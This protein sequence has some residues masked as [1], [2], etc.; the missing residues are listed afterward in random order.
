MVYFGETPTTETPPQTK[1]IGDT[2][3]PALTDSVFRQPHLKLP[4]SLTSKHRKIMHDACAEVGL[5]HFSSGANRKARTMAISAYADGFDEKHLDPSQLDTA[6]T[7]SANA[8]SAAP[9]CQYRP[10]YCRKERQG[11]KTESRQRKSIDALI[12]HPGDCLRESLDALDFTLW[13][14]ADLSNK[15]PPQL[16]DD[17]Q[18]WTLVDSPEKMQQ[19]IDEL[20]AAR[21]TAIAFDLELYNRSKY[22]QLTCLLQLT[23]DTGNRDYVIDTLAPG[24]WDTVHGL[25]PLFADPNIVKVGHA[26]GGLDVRSLHRDFGIFVVNAFDTYEAAQGL[27]M[28]QQGLAAVCDYYGMPASETYLALKKQYQNCNWRQRPLTLPMIQYGRYDVHY[29]LRLRWLMMRDLVR[30]DL[31]D[32]TPSE[33]RAEE[34]RV[35]E[36]VSSTLAL[37]N[38]Y[39]DDEDYWESGGTLSSSFEV[40]AANEANDDE[41]GEGTSGV[42]VEENDADSDDERNP[43]AS[44][45]ILRLQPELMRVISHSQRRCRDLWSS[46]KERF[47]NHPL[48]IRYAQRARRKE[49]EWTLRNEALLERLVEWR[50]GIAQ[51]LECLPGFVAPM[52][53]LLPVA[54][55]RP[56]TEEALRRISIPLPEVLEYEAEHRKALLNVVREFLHS[57]GGWDPDEVLILRHVDIGTGSRRKR[58]HFPWGMAALAAV[59]PTGVAV[60]FMASRRRRI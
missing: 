55:Q 19:C 13:E 2:F 41:E 58:K 16:E 56:T 54:L 15:A 20:T 24:V 29:L 18:T 28:E 43:I 12:D 7:A 4:P 6:T 53:T 14:T 47:V 45:E 9:L 34:Q 17:Q 27:G 57:D 32:Q 48:R 3:F 60:A 42:N 33:R 50:D 31:W 11:D 37:F 22:F 23:S 36:A 46:R 40:V 59:G 49:L 21:P 25:A 39:E 30:H 1:R 38:Q 51:E 44:V 5:Y 35:G 26:I 8:A 52:E 10:W